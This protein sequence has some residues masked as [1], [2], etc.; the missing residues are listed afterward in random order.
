MTNPPR[1]SI[2]Q[3]RRVDASGSEPA[4][5]RRFEVPAAVTDS[6]HRPYT[7]NAVDYI[8]LNTGYQIK[9]LCIIKKLSTLM[10]Q[11]ILKRQHSGMR[12]VGTDL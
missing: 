11:S 1:G 3:E 6:G 9:I 7:P 5:R 4:P 8:S 12:V 2:L 10:V